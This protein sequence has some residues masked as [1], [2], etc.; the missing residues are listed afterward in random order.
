VY[1]DFAHHPTAIAS[2]LDG[3]RRQLNG[4]GRLIAVLEPRSNTM[5]MGIHRQ[6]LA[7]SLAQ[8][9]KVYLYQPDNLDWSLQEVADELA[10]V[11]VSTSVDEL[12]AHIS[13]DSAA[14][15]HVVIMSNGAFGNIHD[16]LLHAL[17]DK[18]S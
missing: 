6:T 12:V 3:A 7:Q 18:S 9:D 14:G 10:A 8:A 4:G 2:T 1:D 11:E 16:K 15:D 13:S 5:R 17:E